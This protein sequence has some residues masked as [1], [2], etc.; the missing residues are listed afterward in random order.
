MSRVFK[1][2]RCE[3]IVDEQENLTGCVFALEFSVL[4]EDEDL[5]NDDPDGIEDIDLCPS[6]ARKLR[7]FLGPAAALWPVEPLL[8]GEQA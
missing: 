6:C 7:E 8:Q 3:V 4:T 1:C 2:D 5:D